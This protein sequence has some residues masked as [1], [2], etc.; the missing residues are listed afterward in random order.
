M[1][2]ILQT[3]TIGSQGSESIRSAEFASLFYNLAKKESPV[4]RKK[5]VTAK[6]KVK[7][8]CT[9]WRTTNSE[10]PHVSVT[11]SG[12]QAVVG[13]GGTLNTIQT[14][15]S[16]V[17][18]QCYPRVGISIPADVTPYQQ[19]KKQGAIWSH[20]EINIADIRR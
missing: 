10:C 18:V 14:T 6:L 1:K 13:C 20:L 4:F 5:L 2:D 19:C 11:I 16:T 9:F 17:K 7:A 12:N 15:K 3:S 8:N